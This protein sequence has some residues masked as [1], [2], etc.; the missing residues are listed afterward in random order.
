MGIKGGE[1]EGG[2]EVQQRS[3]RKGLN[4][5]F[6]KDLCVTPLLSYWSSILGE[7]RR[8]DMEVGDTEVM[9]KSEDFERRLS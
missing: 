4:K 3:N 6:S 7:Q 5:D 1:Y 2:L 8:D 9:R